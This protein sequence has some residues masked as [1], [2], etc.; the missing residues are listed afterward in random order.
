[1]DDNGNA[2]IAW[3]QLKEL[4]FKGVYISERRDGKWSHPENVDN[5]INPEA[6]SVNS[7]KV[8]MGNA[9]NAMVVW[10]QNSLGSYNLYRSTYFDGKWNHPKNANDTI[11]PGT[12]GVDVHAAAVDDNGNALIAWVE[13]VGFFN[14][15]KS[16]YRDGA[17]QDPK[18]TNDSIAPDLFNDFFAPNPKIAMDNHDNA[19]ITFFHFD[20]WS[21][22]Q[23]YRCE[24][25][26]SAWTF[27]KDLA[28]HVSLDGAHADPAAVAMNDLGNA[29]IAWFQMT[30]TGLNLF[31]S[32]YN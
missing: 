17:W 14:L 24:Y 22:S 5:P 8:V 11:N 1:M 6:S 16:E 29:F 30:P 20:T 28:D 7:I 9:D 15:F 3:H 32:E 13:N 31:K 21:K 2:I 26:H 18:D 25:R 12:L 10:K 4:G 27:P 19:I 23:V